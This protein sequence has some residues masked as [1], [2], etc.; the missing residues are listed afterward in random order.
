MNNVK[1][2]VEFATIALISVCAIAAQ[3]GLVVQGLVA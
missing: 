2:A 3:V 1:S